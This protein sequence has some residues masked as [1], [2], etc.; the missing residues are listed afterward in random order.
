MA[1]GNVTGVDP[2]YDPRFQRGYSGTGDTDVPGA[3]PRPQPAPSSQPQRESLEELERRASERTAPKRVPELPSRSFEPRTPVNGTD[4]AT[5]SR[6]GAQAGEST[7]RG[8]SNGDEAAGHS[9]DPPADPTAGA[10]VQQLE[11]PSSSARWFWIAIGACVGF[12]VVGSLLHWVQA[13]DPGIYG[14]GA[15]GTDETTRMFLSAITPAMVQAGVIGA[16]AVLVVWATRGT[17]SGRG[18]R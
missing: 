12:I 13:S 1:E 6:E 8:G 17:R 11:A 2:R 18:P 10:P 4:P 9:D 14:G 16:V 15:M 7:R 5:R 3:S